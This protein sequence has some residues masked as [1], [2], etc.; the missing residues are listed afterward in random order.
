MVDVFGRGALFCPGPLPH[1]RPLRPMEGIIDGRGVN[2]KIAPLP[3][4]S[5][6]SPNCPAK[7]LTSPK[8]CPALSGCPANPLRAAQWFRPPVTVLPGQ[9][10]QSCPMVSATCH[11]A[12]RPSLSELPNGFGHLSPCC[13]AKL[14]PNFVPPFLTARPN[15]SE[16]PNGFGHLIARH[17]EDAGELREGGPHGAPN[18]GEQADFLVHGDFCDVLPIPP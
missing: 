13:S 17:A 12:A 14:S 3:N 4:G 16:L 18:V 7:P 11:R 10:S 8:L 1:S 2:P 5:Q 6:T 9:T 15:L